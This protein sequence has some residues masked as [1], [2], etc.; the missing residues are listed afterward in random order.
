[1]SSTMFSDDLTLQQS[2]LAHNAPDDYF[3]CQ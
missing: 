3:G 2:V 1:M